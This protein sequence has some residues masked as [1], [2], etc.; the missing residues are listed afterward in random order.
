MAWM[1]EVWSWLALRYITEWSLFTASPTALTN[2]VWF[3]I[4]LGLVVASQVV[5]RNFVGTLLQWIPWKLVTF[6]QW[7]LWPWI[8]DRWTVYFYRIVG[9]DT[10]WVE[11][12]RLTCV[13]SDIT[14]VGCAVCVDPACWPTWLYA[15]GV[16]YVTVYVLSMCVSLYVCITVCV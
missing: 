4:S 15:P 2:L 14:W 10:Y 12:V 13:W 16:V 3:S 5:Q 1:E 8:R 7:A 9:F 11:I 6:G